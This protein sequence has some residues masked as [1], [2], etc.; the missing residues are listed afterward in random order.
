MV[1]FIWTTESV[2]QNDGKDIPSSEFI[3]RYELAKFSK[4]ERV[5]SICLVIGYAHSLGKSAYIL[6]SLR[7]VRILSH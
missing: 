5:T 4:N 7:M 1:P 2:F 6:K 3:T